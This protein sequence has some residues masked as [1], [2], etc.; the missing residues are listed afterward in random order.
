[1][2]VSLKQIRAFLAVA[3]LGSFTRAS[4]QIHATQ[5]SLS[6]LIRELEAELGIKLLDR[7]TRKVEVTEAGREF[8]LSAE[9]IVA[10]LQDAVASTRELTARKRG[11]VRVAAAPLCAAAF[12]PRSIAAFRAGHPGISVV[13]EDVQGDEVAAHVS[14]G[15][16]DCGIGVFDAYDNGLD[17]M[18]LTR[19]RL[20]LV[21]PRGHPLLQKRQVRWKDL[22]GQPLITIK[23]NNAARREFDRALEVAGIYGAPLIEATQ[24]MTMPGLVDAK[25]GL[26][27]W[28]SWAHAM[29]RSFDAEIRPLVGPTVA[30]TVAAITAKGRALSPATETFLAALKHYVESKSGRAGATA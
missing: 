18:P 4:A 10:E 1:M 13:L 5:S 26:A 29:V 7:T 6:V 14:S 3:Q 2:N 15:R 24:M 28:P 11:R 12:L 22:A 19:E 20:V 30:H 17:F 25:L 21:C 27:V 8:L 9:R 16:F 23:G